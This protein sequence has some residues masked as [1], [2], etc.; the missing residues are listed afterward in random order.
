MKEMFELLQRKKEEIRDK[1]KFIK[2][3]GNK[4]EYLEFLFGTATLDVDVILKKFKVEFVVVPDEYYHHNYQFFSMANAIVKGNEILKNKNHR[5]QFRKSVVLELNEE[6]FVALAMH[7]F[8][9]IILNHKHNLPE[10]EKITRLMNLENEPI[11]DN[12]QKRLIDK[13]ITWV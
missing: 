12:I 1:V 2:V 3:N 5:I 9:H 10:N 7:E 6:E 11:L 8:I 4:I 13:D